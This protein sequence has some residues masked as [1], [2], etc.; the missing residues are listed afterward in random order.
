M[1]IK[2]PESHA[3]VVGEEVVTVKVESLLPQLS[4]SIAQSVAWPNRLKWL[5]ISSNVVS[6]LSPPNLNVSIAVLSSAFESVGSGVGAGVEQF[7]IAF[8]NL[9]IMTQIFLYIK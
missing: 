2:F 9:K 1:W 3:M 7:K 5:S 6:L 8:L 4:D